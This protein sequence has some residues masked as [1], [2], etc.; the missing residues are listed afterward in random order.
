LAIL[1]PA[2][3]LRSLIPMGFMPM[4]GPGFSVGLML[5]EGYAPEPQPPVAMDMS[6][7]AG[8]DMSA[9]ATAQSADSQR[10]ATN[11]PSGRGSPARQNH[12]ACPYGASPVSAGA[13][14]LAAVSLTPGRS[15]ERA[16]PAPQLTA[17][18]S[19]VRAQS[20]RAPPIPS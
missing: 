13:P 14:I 6:M 1:L 5:C 2:F 16:L 11:G 8:I 7:D 15:P 12:S 9:S 4:F 20:P 17:L 3:V 18:Q 10:G 19:I